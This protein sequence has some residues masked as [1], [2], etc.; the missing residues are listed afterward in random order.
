MTEST[1][2]TTDTS[3]ER[4][5]AAGSNESNRSYYNHHPNSSPRFESKE[6]STPRYLE[7]IS[8]QSNLPQS[9][10][11]SRTNNRDSHIDRDGYELPI[12]CSPTTTR[13]RI[14][15][16][17]IY[18]KP[19]KIIKMEIKADV[20]ASFNDH[21]LKSEKSSNQEEGNLSPPPTYSQVFSDNFP[22][23]GDFDP[24]HRT[25]NGHQSQ[26]SLTPIAPSEFSMHHQNCSSHCS[27]DCDG[28]KMH[29]NNN[30]DGEE[31]DQKKAERMIK[32]KDEV[33]GG[34]SFEITFNRSAIIINGSFSG[35][36][37]LLH[38]F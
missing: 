22:T 36:S 18:D 20:I 23:N 31:L 10:D 24:Y 19:N 8:S 17:S 13:N 16:Q 21:D 15:N 12:D 5:V 1:C 34:F 30:S 27:L 4:I 33:T 14:T 37:V 6:S 3:F 11:Q 35:L 32:E 25:L 2:F 7:V 26:H 28:T 38:I 29:H 9:T